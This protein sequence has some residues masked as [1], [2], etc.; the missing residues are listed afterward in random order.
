MLA[1][2]EVNRILAVRNPASTNAAMAEMVLGKLEGLEWGR[3]GRLK[4]VETI[5]PSKSNV[6]NAEIIADSIQPG[7]AVLS[8][9]GDGLA[10]DAFNGLLLAEAEGGI[11]FGE[12]GLLAC[13][14]GSGNDLSASLYPGKNLL[15]GDDLPDLLRHPVLRP[16]DAIRVVKGGRTQH[17]VFVGIG[18]TGYG[19]SQRN[20]PEFRANRWPGKLG[21]V[22]DQKIVLDAV[23]NRREFG[24]R[25]REN[26]KE[27]VH[28]QDISYSLVPRIAGGDIRFDTEPFDNRMVEVEISPEDF[29]RQMLRKMF[30]DS[31]IGRR[32]GFTNGIKG[33]TVKEREITV[34]DATLMHYN[35]EV[36]D[37][38]ADTKLS[39]TRI[40]KVVNI[41]LLDELK[42]LQAS[43]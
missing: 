21:R 20:D 29:H 26:G 40:P 30:W 8:L 16:M 27:A 33:N 7:D 24:F 28:A 42:K 15:E 19:A 34:L 32:L 14:L 12:V 11:R 10:N 9:G 18:L 1:G 41:V 17:A 31:K 35:G 4:E 2:F 3:H 38:P 39:V 37:V 5:D 43:R 36:E 25:Y 23:K 13:P 22:S 6:T